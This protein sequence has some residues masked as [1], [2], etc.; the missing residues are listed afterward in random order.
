VIEENRNTRL[1]MFF[2]VFALAQLVARSR[3]KTKTDPSR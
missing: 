1:G 2:F 3:A